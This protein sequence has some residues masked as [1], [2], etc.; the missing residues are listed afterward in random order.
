MIKNKNFSASINLADYKLFWVYLFLVVVTPIIPMRPL[1]PFRLDDIF[2]IGLFVYV[3]IIKPL[4]LLKHRELFPV[5]LLIVGAGFLFLSTVFNGILS[6]HKT[7]II[8]DLYDVGII[9][10]LIMVN[11]VMRYTLVSSQSVYSTFKCIYWLVVLS[12]LLSLVQ[13]YQIGTI[14]YKIFQLY[15]PRDNYGVLRYV[16]DTSR[17]FGTIG[18]PNFLGMTC[19]LGMLLGLGLTYG[20][21][22]VFVRVLSLTLLPFTIVVATGSRSAT[23]LSILGLIIFSIASASFKKFSPLFIILLSVGC[24]LALFI[25]GIIPLH[26]IP[27]RV[28]VLVEGD[29][30]SVTHIQNY[31]ARVWAWS[32]AILDLY[33]NGGLLL[34]R[35]SFTWDRFILDNSFVFFLYKGGIL[36]FLWFSFLWLKATTMSFKLMHNR[37]DKNTAFI[38]AVFISFLISA[39]IFESV[40]DGFM[41]TKYSIF[42]ITVFTSIGILRDCI[43]C[44]QG[45]IYE[46]K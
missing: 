30:T 15:S 5:I 18:N 38:G 19:F 2:L 40:A 14:G 41:S 43:R 33:N 32:D 29:L 12:A 25:S 16:F 46:K 44:N 7:F 17:A 4:P 21:F 9:V 26:Y 34:G 28:L 22:T 24:V 1:P 23:V 10:R 39:F 35:G 42:L 6:V 37:V 31:E 8:G 11:L 3:V 20:R 36:M 13:F 27:Y 45:H